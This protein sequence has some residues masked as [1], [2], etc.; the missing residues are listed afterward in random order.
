MSLRAL[1]RKQKKI[2]ATQLKTA[3]IKK[4]VGRRKFLVP[5]TELLVVKMTPLLPPH[6]VMLRLF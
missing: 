5:T 2:A 1:N 6:P 4:L 3:M